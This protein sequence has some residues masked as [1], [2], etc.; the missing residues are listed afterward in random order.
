MSHDTLRDVNAFSA[1]AILALVALQRGA[2]LIY[3]SRNVR[4]LKARGGIEHGRL[5]YPVLVA[6]HVSWL[7]AIGVA[8]GPHP[9]IYWLP[10]ALVALLQTM[11]IW[12]LVTLRGFWT[13]RV[14][15]VPGA[16]LVQSGPYRYFRHPN[17]MV[18]VGEVATLPLA[19]GQFANAVIFS[20]LNLAVLAWRVKVESAALGPR[21]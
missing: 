19:F 12:V 7:V 2:E 16:P 6:L 1:Y 11:R 14:I 10:L 17:Y 4:A 8:I 13:T 18:V 15:T 5:H 3:A 20:I 21:R 9:T